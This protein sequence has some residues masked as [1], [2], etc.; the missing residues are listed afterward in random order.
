LRANPFKSSGTLR[1][2]RDKNQPTPRIWKSNGL[3]IN[4]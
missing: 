3:I 1:G 4:N 2:I